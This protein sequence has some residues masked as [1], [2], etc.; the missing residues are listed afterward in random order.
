[1]ARR[2]KTDI[3]LSR[4]LKNTRNKIYRF[5]KKGLS[6]AQIAE[7]DPRRSTKGMTWAQK[8]AYIKELQAFNGRETGY[9][10]RPDGL[11]EVGAVPTRMVREYQRVEREVNR[12]K[13]RLRRAAEGRYGN[14]PVVKGGN[15]MSRADYEE[16]YGQWVKSSDLAYDRGYLAEVRR[17]VGFSSVEQLRRAIDAQRKALEKVRA[18]DTNL[19][20]YKQSIV[21]KLMEENAPADVVTGV[22]NLTLNQLQYLYYNSDFAAEVSTFHYQSYYAEG[23]LRPKESYFEDLYD[24]LRVTL[25]TAQRVIPSTSFSPL[26]PAHGTAR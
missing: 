9:T 21:N 19:A 15:V 26:I 1:M 18:V 4:V 12:E 14:L 5:R 7:I 16:Q 11:G 25:E 22:R 13:R 3:E 23:Y 24:N 10:V 17:D 8:R 6:E 2:A 20:S